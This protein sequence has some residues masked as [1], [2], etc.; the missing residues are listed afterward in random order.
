[1]FTKFT[2]ITRTFSKRGNVVAF[3]VRYMVNNFMMSFSFC[4]PDNRARFAENVSSKWKHGRQKHVE[5]EVITW[6]RPRK[7]LVD[8]WISLPPGVKAIVTTHTWHASTCTL[9]QMYFRAWWIYG[10]WGFIRCNWMPRSGGSCP[11]WI[12]PANLW[13]PSMTTLNFLSV[14]IN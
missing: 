11:I 12:P 9:A 5:E 4:I 7:W 8:W 3:Q 1:M 10:L 14:N 2:V 13:V 6:L